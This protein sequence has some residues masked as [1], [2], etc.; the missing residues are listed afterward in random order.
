M[1]MG[2]HQSRHDKPPSDVYG[3]PSSGQWLGW[4]SRLNALHSAILYAQEPVFENLK[5][6]VEC[7][8]A[9]IMNHDVERGILV[10]RTHVSKLWEK[11]PR[12][13]EERHGL[14]PFSCHQEPVFPTISWAIR[15]TSS[16][17]LSTSRVANTLFSINTCPFT[18]EVTTSWPETA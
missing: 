1:G 8:N 6:P 12:H 2:V 15:F 17:T 14:R 13:Q 16:I 18:I 3:L 9:A 11:I 4:R 5:G 10:H 7:Q